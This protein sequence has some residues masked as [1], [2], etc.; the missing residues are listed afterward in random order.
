MLIRLHGVDPP[1]LCDIAAGGVR[2]AGDGVHV[3]LA[4]PSGRLAYGRPMAITLSGEELRELL[5]RA[6]AE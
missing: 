3:E 2:M 6:P 1:V 5:A 4:C